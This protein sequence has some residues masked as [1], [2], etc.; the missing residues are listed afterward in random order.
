MERLQTAIAKARAARGEA[1]GDDGGEPGRQSGGTAAGE[2]ARAGGRGGDR[3]AA[4]SWSEVP[5]FE[6][7]PKR[8]ERGRI[9]AAS[10]GR[11]A[12]EF[13]KLRTRIVQ[14][15]Q[16]NGWRRIAITSPG[17]G[18]GKS[19][20]ALNLAYGLSRQDASRVMLCETDLR[21]PSL[22][23]MLG[24]PPGRDFARV[25]E[26]R[27]RFADNAVRLRDNLMAGLAER[28]RGDTA[29]LLHAS[30]A[31]DALDTVQAAY[32]PTVMLLDTPPVLVSDDTIGLL[33]YVDCALI[34][35]AA[36][37]TSIAEIDACEREASAR[38]AVIGVVLNKCRH[39]D[40]GGAYDYYYE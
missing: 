1:L 15:M 21:R 2:G 22:A 12:T 38:T 23:R 16:A 24:V 20:V 26:G 36:G 35:A 18:C 17:P 13:D 37:T 27:G 33:D 30:G 25:L 5:S 29:E 3:S 34:V 11:A 40:G 9:V 32:A 6:P 7:D 14:Q 8:L 31:R 28:A 4:S 19:T 10:G 39:P